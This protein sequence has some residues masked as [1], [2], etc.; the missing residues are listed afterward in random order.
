M[1]ESIFSGSSTSF[2]A[3]VF[4][5]ESGSDMEIYRDLDVEDG[6]ITERD[7]R[8]LTELSV[9]WDFDI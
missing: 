2:D 9:R 6:S 7:E 1:P 8:I 4:D 3:D 5:A